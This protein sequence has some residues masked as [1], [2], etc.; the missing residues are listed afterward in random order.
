MI[1]QS[2]PIPF[3][4]YMARCLY[5]PKQGYYSRPEVPTVSK[6]GDFMTSVSV[7]PVF[8]RILAAR[9]HQFWIGNGRPSEFCVLEPGGHDGSLAKDI[10]SGA[11]QIDPGFTHALQYHVYEPHPDRRKLLSERLGERATVIASPDELQAPIGAIVANEVLDALPVPLFLHSGKKWHEVA[12]TTAGDQFTW[13]TR[14]TNFALQGDYP[15][16]YV[17]EGSPDLAPFLK[18][19]AEIFEKALFVFIDYGLDEESL[20]HPDRHVGT[21]RC[22]RN[23]RSNVHP[24]DEPGTRDLTADVNFSAVERVAA[25]LGLAS[26]PL[27]NQS[28]YL[29]Y[30]GRDWLLEAPTAAEVRQ[31]QTLIHPSQFGNRF[32]V[33]E[34]TKGEVSRSFPA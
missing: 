28:R 27:M 16:G 2:G 6:E 33:A 25:E 21:L 11:S 29:T 22:Y 5:D 14:K 3:R 32:H 20:Y 12:V 9:L 31:F 8:G 34:F 23:H 4:D 1:D 24:L 19:L 30:C 10:L 15:D 18:P 7:G 13:T 26:H 17:T